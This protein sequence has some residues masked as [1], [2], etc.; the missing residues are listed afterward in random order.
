[1]K[2]D[3]GNVSVWICSPE[4]LIIQKTVANRDKDWLDIEGLLMQQWGKLDHEYIESW[5][6]QFSEALERIE[7]E[8]KYLS[9]KKKV[10]QIFT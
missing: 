2:R 10:A 9:L 3:L 8:S 4:D 7:P 5:L 1:V 6:S